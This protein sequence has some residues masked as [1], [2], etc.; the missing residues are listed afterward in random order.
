VMNLVQMS[1]SDSDFLSISTAPGLWQGQRTS[2]RGLALGDSGIQR[3]RGRRLAG[4][5][6][7]VK[8]GGAWLAGEKALRAAQK[9]LIA[10]QKALRAPGKAPRAAQKERSAGLEGLAR[11]WKSAESRS[12]S[13][14]RKAG[15]PCTP[16]KKCGARHKKGERQAE[17]SGAR[18]KKC[19]AP[20]GTG[21][22]QLN[23]SCLPPAAFGN[24]HPAW[25]RSPA[26]SWPPPPLARCRRPGPAA[27]GSLAQ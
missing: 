9:A 27:S 21:R 10:Q 22:D 8:G 5:A 6:P 18:L 26:R 19:R 17:K 7:R 1:L 20:A 13:V 12:K 3:G 16:R 2:G 14:G 11:G 25:H 23:G 15:E 4:R 24:T